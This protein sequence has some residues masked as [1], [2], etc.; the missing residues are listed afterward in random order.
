MIYVGGL[1]TKLKAHIIQAL[2]AAGLPVADD[3]PKYLGINP[4]NICNRSLTGKGVQLEVSRHLRGCD[5]ACRQ[6]AAAIQSALCH[7]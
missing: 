5:D 4:R 1:D 6:I 7:L 2:R 3:H